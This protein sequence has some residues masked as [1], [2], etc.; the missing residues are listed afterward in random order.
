M[1]QD[2]KGLPRGSPESAP[3]FESHP[4][5]SYAITF[6]FSPKHDIN[7]DDLVFGK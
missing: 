3:F 2:F 5:D 4:K 1:N 6:A 7:G